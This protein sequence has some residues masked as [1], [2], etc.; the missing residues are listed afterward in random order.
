[1]SEGGSESFAGSDAYTDWKSWNEGF[2]AIAKGD[3][4]YFTRELRGI[5]R[6]RPPQDVLEIGFGNGAFLAYCRS[7]G[8]P[9]IGTELSAAQVRSGREADFDVYLS[10][11]TSA[12]GD[13][14][15]DL[16]AAFDVL[17]HIPPA[18]SVNFLADLAGRLR[19][20]GHLFLRY[21]NAD[22]WLG[23]PHQNGDPTHV[24]AIGYHKMSFLAHGAGLRIV[25]Y[26]APVRRGF[27]TSMIH[28]IHSMTAG[29][30]ISV[31]AGI[32]KGLYFPGLP[33]VL[34]SPNVV[35]VLTRS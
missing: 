9:V 14:S 31:L 8:W 23:N 20:G 18:D 7:Q 13:R 11:E 34:S 29:P 3:L 15:F 17:E 33:Y 26:R 30:L 12:F 21:P 10:D 5:A 32:Q 2:G 4:D 25:E 28:G 35:C 16:I 19:P 27:S 24:N 1:M 6:H 22:T